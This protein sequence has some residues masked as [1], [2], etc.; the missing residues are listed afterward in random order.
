MSQLSL[1]CSELVE[2]TQSIAPSDTGDSEFHELF[3][4]AYQ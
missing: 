2:K 3:S 4:G 1:L